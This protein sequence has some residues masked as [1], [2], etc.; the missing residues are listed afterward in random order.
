M[1]EV[2]DVWG[3]LVNSYPHSLDECYYVSSIL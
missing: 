1:V 3:G 2:F